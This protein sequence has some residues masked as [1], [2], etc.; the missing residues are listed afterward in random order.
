MNIIHIYEEHYT[1]IANIYLQ[2]IAT[3]NAT[4]QTT[5]PTWKSWDESYLQPSRLAAFINNEMVGWAALSPVSSCCVYAGVAEVS[6]YIA[7][8]FW[9]K[10]IGFQLL[11]QLIL[12]SEEIG[13][14]TL[15]SGI[16]PENIGSIK[17]HE[18]CGFRQIGYREKIG[19]M[20][21]VWRDNIMMEKRSKI[22][23]I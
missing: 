12:A 13:L 2:G 6:I 14:W 20:N 16:F 23:G 3:G 10:G 8:D 1:E 4:F 19:Q 22:V 15:Q 9:G 5:A 18:K 11:N 21:G 17:L 7:S